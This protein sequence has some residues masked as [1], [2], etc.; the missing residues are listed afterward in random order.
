MS[1]FT[2][3]SSVDLSNSYRPTTNTNSYKRTIFIKPAKALNIA[4]NTDKQE[5]APGDNISISFGTTD[6]VS[7][8]HLDVY[9]RQV[10]SNIFVIFIISFLWFSIWEYLVAV[11]LEKLFKTKYWDYSALKFN[12][13][14][15]V[16]LKNSIYWGILGVLLVFVIQP[17]IEKATNLIPGNILI[18]IDVALCVAI[19]V[20]MIITIF[21]TMSIDKKLRQVFEIG[22]SIKEKLKELKSAEV[23]GL[24][25]IH[26]CW[27]SRWTT[28]R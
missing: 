23:L 10:S 28:Y 19:F 6:A 26:I 4:I 25:L 1:D 20:D 15:R 22:E 12:I 5:Y 18:Y 27:S 24:S 21:K 3:S 7:Y 2:T 9:K 8:T 11:V 16:C 13:H 17:Q 14:G